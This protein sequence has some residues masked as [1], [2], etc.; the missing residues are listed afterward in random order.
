M[1]LNTRTK[2][3]LSGACLLLA[4]AFFTTVASAGTF[5]TIDLS[6]SDS[7]FSGVPVL[8]TGT[9]TGSI[10][11]QSI[12][13]TND[14]N[15]IYLNVSFYT[16]VNPDDGSAGASTP[17]GSDGQELFQAI[18]TDANPATGDNIY[19]NTAIGSEFGEDPYNAFQQ[20]PGSTDFNT[21]TL[22][23][24]DDALVTS[25]D[26]STTDQII[27]IPLSAVNLS[28]GPVFTQSAIDLELYTT[29][30]SGTVSAT[31]PIAY[32]LATPEPTTWGLLLGGFALMVFIVRRRGVSV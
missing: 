27:A 8:Y 19:G 13:I 31:G 4:S 10:P 26:S 15:Y 21:G 11:I 25:F 1:K 9:D 17:G 22:P 23:A 20:G 28:G 29:G 5:E 3:S 24:A 14:A 12:Q 16:A 32:T 2:S 30:G 6:G 7:Q 18:D